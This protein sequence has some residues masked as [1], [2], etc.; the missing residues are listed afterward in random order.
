MR[1]ALPGVSHDD[2]VAMG[3]P[4]VIKEARQLVTVNSD[5][6]RNFTLRNALGEIRRQ[7]VERQCNNS[8]SAQ[9]TSQPA[10]INGPAISIVVA[11]REACCWIQARSPY[12]GESICASGVCNDSP[13][14][15]RLRVNP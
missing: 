12:M 5:E 2:R 1:S 11:V 9:E 6:A 4:R 7:T 8:R 13:A 10:A 14:T 15:K 3:R